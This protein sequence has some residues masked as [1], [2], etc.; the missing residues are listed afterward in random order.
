MSVIRGSCL[1]GEIR[2]QFSRDCIR[3]I[4]NCHCVA[5]RKVSGAAY[6]TMVQVADS[7]FSWL[8]GEGSIR[9]FESS[10]DNHR[11]FCGQCGTRM[12]QLQPAASNV[13]IPAGCLDDDLGAM[14]QVNMWIEEKVEWGEGAN[15]APSCEGRGSPEFWSELLGGS[16]DLYRRIQDG[17]DTQDRGIIED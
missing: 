13:A 10:A 7:G 12:P 16:P 15:V 2:F 4:N 14:P 9:S 5:C 1:C 3:L 17:T 8:S 11:A 6:G